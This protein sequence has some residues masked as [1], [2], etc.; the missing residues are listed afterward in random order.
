MQGVPASLVFNMAQNVTFPQV[1]QSLIDQC[2]ADRPNFGHGKV[3]SADANVYGTK[4]VGRNKD[5]GESKN[6]YGNNGNGNDNG[7]GVGND[8]GNSGHA[9]G[10]S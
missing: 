3:G 1:P 2:K 5:D 9:Y 8:K 6:V 4:D 10:H 7:K